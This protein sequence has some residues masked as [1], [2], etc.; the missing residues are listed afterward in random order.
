MKQL[1]HPPM[2]VSVPLSTHPEDQLTHPLLNTIRRIALRYDFKVFDVP[3]VQLHTYK[4]RVEATFAPAQMAVRSCKV[5]QMVHKRRHHA[6]LHHS[7]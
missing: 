6:I 1:Q 4:P 2:S 7:F 5:V 3:V